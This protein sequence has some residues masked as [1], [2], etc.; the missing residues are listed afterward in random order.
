MTEFSE[1][2]YGRGQ[3]VELDGNVYRR[4]KFDG[5]RMR[6]SGGPLPTFD[7]CRII[8]VTWAF[9]GPAG[10]AF[11]FLSAIHNHFGEPGRHAAEEMIRNIKSGNHR[12]V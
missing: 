3:T 2:T 5:S 1:Q 12:P 6:F 9:G 7:D 8:D 10:N 11:K 4:C